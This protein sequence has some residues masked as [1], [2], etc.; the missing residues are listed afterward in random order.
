MGE[1]EC[2]C[3]LLEHEAN[4]NLKSCWGTA[5][6]AAN[7]HR[8]LDTLLLLLDRGA[9][10]DLQRAVG[11]Q[12]AYYTSHEKPLRKARRVINSAPLEKKDKKRSQHDLKYVSLLPR[13]SQPIYL[14]WCFDVSEALGQASNP[15]WVAAMPGTIEKY[16]ITIRNKCH[17]LWKKRGRGVRLGEI[18]AALS[19]WLIG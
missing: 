8:D 16:N 4:M 10:T 7:T 17:A 12:S 15:D 3:E 6:T 18:E 5:L 14:H 9:S 1:S 2:I 19:D 11:L 13:C